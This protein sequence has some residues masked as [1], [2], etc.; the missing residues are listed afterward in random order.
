[1]EM[2]VGE[3][4][5]W[6]LVRELLIL[7]FLHCLVLISHYFHLRTF[8]IHYNW[9]SLGTECEMAVPSQR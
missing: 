7:S 6:L 8:K 5:W 3:D 2:L 4:L 1:M 9:E